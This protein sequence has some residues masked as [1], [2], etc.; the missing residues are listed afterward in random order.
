MA[1]AIETKTSGSVDAPTNFP[2]T[3]TTAVKALLILFSQVDDTTK[4]VITTLWNTTEEFTLYNTFETTWGRSDVVTQFLNNPTPGS[5]NVNVTRDDGGRGGCIIWAITDVRGLPGGIRQYQTGEVDTATS[6]SL[7]VAQA[8][9]LD[10]V[11][12]GGAQSGGAGVQSPAAN[13]TEDA[14][15]V[16]VDGRFYAGHRTPGG[17]PVGWSSA[18]DVARGGIAIVLELGES[19]QQIIVAV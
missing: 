8:V 3:I 15:F 4:P 14:D 19:Q 6:I 7:A 18:D 11:L 2:L 12:F 1:I 5:H 13:C 9:P 16:I 17:T 10:L